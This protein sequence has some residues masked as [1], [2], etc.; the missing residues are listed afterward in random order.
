MLP[1]VM[2]IMIL[3]QLVLI[4]PAL[5]MAF[6]INAVTI[7]IF[8]NKLVLITFTTNFKRNILII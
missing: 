7:A 1:F 2:N 4:T 8:T 3:E 5:A 6:Q